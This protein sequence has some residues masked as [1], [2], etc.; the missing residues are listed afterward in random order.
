MK[1]KNEWKDENET[2][3]FFLNI[4]HK[5]NRFSNIEISALNVAIVVNKTGWTDGPTDG[6]TKWINE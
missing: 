1:R 6:R 3:F 2:N 4:N 5:N